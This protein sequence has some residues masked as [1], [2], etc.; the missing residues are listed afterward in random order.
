MVLDEVCVAAMRAHQSQVPLAVDEDHVACAKEIGVAIQL[1][2]AFVV[3]DRQ[4][5][6]CR[7][8]AFLQRDR[9]LTDEALAALASFQR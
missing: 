2:A 4:V 7:H 5:D 3:V 6:D 8:A 1:V 9:E